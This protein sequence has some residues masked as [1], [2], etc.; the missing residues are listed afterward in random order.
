MVSIL[1]IKN[2]KVQDQTKKISFDLSNDYEYFD[3]SVEDFYTKIS[4]ELKDNNITTKKLVSINFEDIYDLGYESFYDFNY[5]IELSNNDTIL[6]YSEDYGKT[7]SAIGYDFSKNIDG[8]DAGFFIG[9]VS[10]LFMQPNFNSDEFMEKVVDD[11]LSR[12]E[13]YADNGINARYAYN[14]ILYGIDK[15]NS[16]DEEENY[17]FAIL[18][19]IKETTNEDWE[20]NREKEWEEWKKQYEQ[21]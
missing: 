9:R 20:N 14:H 6:L 16:A 15:N 10:L 11:F 7:I 21:E 13:T 1:M 5:A 18:A 3:I 8:K 17:M 4:Q 19:P 12:E 2:K